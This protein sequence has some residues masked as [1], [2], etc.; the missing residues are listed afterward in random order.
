MGSSRLLIA[1][2]AFVVACADSGDVLYAPEPVSPIEVQPGFFRVTIDPAPDYVRGFTPQGDTILF[3]GFRGLILGTGDSAW[4]ILGAPVAGGHGTREEAAL[5]RAVFTR[6]IGTIVVRP[7]DR[8]VTTWQRGNDRTF[9]GPAGC[10][11]FNYVRV[12]RMILW[13][14]PPDDGAALS[15]IPTWRV[16]TPT[17]DTLIFDPN[18]P[19][20][21]IRYRMRFNLA[22]AEVV[23]GA[24]PYGPAAATDG[25]TV[26]Y[27]DG[28]NLWRVPLADPAAA[29]D[30]LGPGFFPALSPDGSLLA[31]VNPVG[32][33]SSFAADTVFRLLFKCIQDNWTMTASGFTTTVVKSAT[34]DTV[35]VVPG[36]EPVF[37]PAGTRLF[38]RRP[39]G[40]VA[41]DLASGV[42]TLLDNTAGAFSLAVSPDGAYLAF[43]RTVSRNTDVY[44]VTLK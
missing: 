16:R 23:S 41:V 4:Q 40:I 8:L 39:E 5:Y 1:A 27:S 12:W 35:R 11:P 33:D 22:E 28:D 2:T 21:Q 26:V 29:R 43:S 19:V 17:V 13:R 6:P 3:R 15:S 32:L 20:S 7:A 14:L 34:G 24:N 10:E 30:S 37:D 18:L 9:D 36:T 25:S 38:V 44:Y 31:S 42:E